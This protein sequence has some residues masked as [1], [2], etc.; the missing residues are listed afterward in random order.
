MTDNEAKIR[1]WSIAVERPEVVG[2]H[3][4]LSFGAGIEAR[5]N[6]K[7]TRVETFASFRDTPEGFECVDVRMWPEDSKVGDR[8][9]SILVTVPENWIVWASWCKWGALIVPFHFGGEGVP[10]WAADGGET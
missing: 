1:P 2:L 4:V 5:C 3:A 10:L 6:V 7:R 9:T 8:Y